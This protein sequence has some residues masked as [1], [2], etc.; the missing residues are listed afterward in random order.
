MQSLVAQDTKNGWEVR[1]LSPEAFE[2]YWPKIQAMLMQVPHTWE[3]YT[4]DWFYSAAMN[5]LMQVWVVGDDKIRMVIFSK[6]SIYPAGPILDLIWAA[7]EG[8]HQYAMEIMDATLDR[9][10]QVNGCREIV[11]TGRFG[12]ES[13]LKPR[14]FKRTHVVMT[15]HVAHERIQ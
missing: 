13:V 1:L 8:A 2:H 4:L 6:I 3:D 15:R 5:Q 7:G 12:W 10:A 9:F 11:A 14:G